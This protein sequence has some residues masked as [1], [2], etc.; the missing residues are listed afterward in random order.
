MSIVVEA[1]NLK[2]NYNSFTAVDGIAFTISRG[3]CFGILGPNGAGKTTV[4]AM[5]YCFHP[6]TDGKLKVLGYDVNNDSRVIK[7]RLGVVPQENNLDQELSIRENLLVYAS[8]YGI[9]REIAKKRADELL[10]FFDLS[11]KATQEVEQISGGMKRRLT[12]ARGLIHDPE[13]LILD[14]PTTGLDPQSR[15]L[16]WE[17]L[18]WLKKRGLT[19]ILTT[20]YLE[21]ASQLCDD[22]I[23]MNKGIILEQGQPSELISHHVG[24]KVIEVEIEPQLQPFL[25]QNLENKISGYQVAGNTVYLFISN[26]ESRVLELI[27]LNNNV[28]T[29]Q[30]RPSNLEDVFLKLTGR[31]LIYEEDT[32]HR[33]GHH[34]ESEVSNQIL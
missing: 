25:L 16:I 2:K 20:H 8:Y 27:N 7:T 18:R 34:P 26:D 6:V 14:E 19:L 21:E 15:R 24:T 5:I 3:Q 32:V 10:Y 28:Q 31:G 17:H 1:E 23:I 29:Y 13:I 9:N 30:V 33:S 11:A 22:L 12:I 4:V